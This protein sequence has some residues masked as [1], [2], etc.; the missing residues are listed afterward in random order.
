MNTVGPEALLAQTTQPWLIKSR[1]DGDEAL[2]AFIMPKE[3]E[4]STFSKGNVKVKKR[5]SGKAFSFFF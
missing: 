5:K 4:V 2:M 1:I 3:K